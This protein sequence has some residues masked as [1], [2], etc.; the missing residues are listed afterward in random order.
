MSKFVS[1]ETWLV[2]RAGGLLDGTIWTPKGSSVA[3]AQAEAKRE[4][5]A[6]AQAVR[7]PAEQVW[8]DIRG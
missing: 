3:A 5:G 4:H 7:R 8:H 1:V 6:N 2:R